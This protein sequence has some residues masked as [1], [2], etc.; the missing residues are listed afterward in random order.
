MAEQADESGME[1]GVAAALSRRRLLQASGAFLIAAMVGGEQR[2][3]WP[4]EARAAGLPLAPLTAAEGAIIER[5]GSILA[6]GAGEAGLAHFLSAQ[7]GCPHADSLL[8]LRYLDWPP[9]YLDFYRAGLAA[10]EDSARAAHGAAFTALAA[11]DAEALVR[12]MATGTP[13]GWSAA[14]PAPLFYFVIRADA[15]DVAYG[16][17]AGFARLGVPYMGHIDPSPAW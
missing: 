14:V 12:A 5:L 15:V 8:I 17:M 1:A 7:L 16:T 11:A 13:A 2:L 6:I 3:L 9:P 4:H 10:L